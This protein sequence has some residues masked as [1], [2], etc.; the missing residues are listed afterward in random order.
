MK[1]KEGVRKEDSTRTTE[2]MALA[3]PSGLEASMTVAAMP[4]LLIRA[5]E[6]KEVAGKQANRSTYGVATETDL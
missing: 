2:H 1:E 5:Q 6:E 4:T 3:H